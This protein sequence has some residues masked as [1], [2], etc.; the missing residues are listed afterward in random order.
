MPVMPNVKRDAEGNDAV[1]RP[2]D[3]AVQ[4]LP[5]NDLGHWRIGSARGSRALVA[6]GV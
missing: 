2:D 4:E 6:V 5:E 3:D 1:Q